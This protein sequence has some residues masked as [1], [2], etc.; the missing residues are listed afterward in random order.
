MTTSRILIDSNAF[1]AGKPFYG[2]PQSSVRVQIGAVDKTGNLNGAGVG[3]VYTDTYLNKVVGRNSITATI[4]PLFVDT[5]QLTNW[6]RQWKNSMADLVTKGILI[7]ES[8][9][10]SVLT[11]AAVLAL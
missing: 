9:A 8:P 3:V 10:G 5:A 1:G 7:V 11:A 4:N 6:P 2:Q